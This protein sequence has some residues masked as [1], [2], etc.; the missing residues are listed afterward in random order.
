MDAITV[1][2]LK[3][4]G[5]KRWLVNARPELF[6]FR[7]ERFIEPFLGSGAVY[8]YIQ[9]RRAV[10]SDVN[11]ELILAY[12]VIREDWRRIKKELARHAR[13]HSVAHYYAVRSATS[14]K[15]PAERAARFI[16]LNR[17]CWNGLYRVNLKGQFNVPI[18]TKSSVLMD[19][20]DFGL[21]AGLLKGAHIN[22]HDFE[23][24]INGALEDDFLFVDPPYTVKH[25]LN[26]FIKYN[27]N[28][29]S[30]EDQVRLKNSLV[31]ADR[32]GVKILMTNA[33]HQSIRDL[34]RGSFRLESISRNSV[35]SGVKQRR[36]FVT[37]LLVRNW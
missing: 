25:N 5:G 7:E 24:T 20:D 34:Y 4:A 30:W 9:P 32:R 1:P 15:S 14:F 3:W 31:R 37:E 19:S 18:G 10:L 22:C 21:T 13:L 16:Y 6:E 27:E 29:F 33:D 35:L 2:F 17:T 23:V 11:Q 8:F 36:G 12:Q 26:G 28:L